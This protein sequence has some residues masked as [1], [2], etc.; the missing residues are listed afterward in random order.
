MPTISFHASTTVAKRIR[1]ASKKR[2][3]PMSKFLRE[4]A[5]I[6]IDRDTASFADWAKK[7]AGVVK[8]GRGD[9]SQREGFGA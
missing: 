5:E 7:F 9:L 1:A 6:A 2:G 8:S 3:V 4:A